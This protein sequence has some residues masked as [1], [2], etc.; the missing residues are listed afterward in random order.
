LRNLPRFAAPIFLRVTT[1]MQATGN[2]KQQKHVL[3]TEGVDPGKVGATDKLYWLQG[4]TY[5]PF[6]E[7][8]W[9]R[10]QGGQVKL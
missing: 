5:V 4:D 7:K 2:N 6:E 1:E 9:N 8:D 10:L 3:R